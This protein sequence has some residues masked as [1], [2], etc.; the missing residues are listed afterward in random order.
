MVGKN[1][2]SQLIEKFYSNSFL[3]S[4]TLIENLQKI[5]LSDMNDSST[6]NHEI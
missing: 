4:L 6:K 2:Y 5:G 3:L 1:F